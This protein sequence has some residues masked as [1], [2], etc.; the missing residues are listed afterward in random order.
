M[1]RLERRQRN[2]RIAEASQEVKRLANELGIAIIEV[3][4]F[5][6]EGAKS[7]Q[8][9]LHDLE[10]SGQLEK[11]ASLIFILELSE[12]EFTDDDRRKYLEAKVRIVKGRNVGKSEV[13]GKF[14]GRS[15]QF[16]F[17]VRK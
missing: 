7:I 5:N 14:Y 4:Q 6:R 15:V 2:E 3:A 13:V 11:D 9:G 10:G 17:E 12:E 16:E 8:A 1:E